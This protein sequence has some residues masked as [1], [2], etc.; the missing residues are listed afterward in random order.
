MPRPIGELA[1]P[2][3]I[4]DCL[5]TIFG[6][7]KSVCHAKLFHCQLHEQNI[8]LLI[9][10]QQDGLMDGCTHRVIP[11]LIVAAQTCCLVGGT[12][13]TFGH[14]PP[15]SRFRQGVAAS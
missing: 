7:L 1:A 9:F 6:H 12:R 13:D 2:T 8:V 5:R 3:E 10:D 4:V 11:P 14:S 15:A